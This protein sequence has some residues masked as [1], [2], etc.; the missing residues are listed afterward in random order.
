MEVADSLMTYRSRYQSNLDL[1]NVLTLMLTDDDNPRSLVFQL[2]SLNQSVQ[3]LPILAKTE[4]LATHQR[5][6][7]EALHCAR[8]VQML[9]LCKLDGAGRHS[10]LQDLCLSMESTLP[11]LSVSISNQYFIHSGPIHQMNQNG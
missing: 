5:L 11:Q 8:M 9:E 3:S 6:S 2:I 7:M 4:T 10:G 1:E